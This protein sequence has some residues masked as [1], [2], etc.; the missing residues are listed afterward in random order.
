MRTREILLEA[1]RLVSRAWTQGATARDRKGHPVPYYSPDAYSF[2]ALGAIQR[3]LGTHP[4]VAQIRVARRAC[5]ES[6]PKPWG[7]AT[8]NDHPGR[9]AREV[10]QLLKGAALA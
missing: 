4:N 3:A 8:W 10:V 5:E 2:C 7:L 6:I 9:T 1:A